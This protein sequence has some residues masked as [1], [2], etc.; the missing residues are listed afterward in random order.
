M[1]SQ[2]SYAAEGIVLKRKSAG[3]ADRIL[4]IFT[5]QY[6]KIRV[7]AKGIRKVGSRRSSYLE[8]F[9]H[10]RFMLVKS[11]SMDILTEVES[12]GAAPETHVNLSSI[13]G[14]Y[15]VCELVDALLPEKM[16]HDEVY[17]LLLRAL[18]AV[19]TSKQPIVLAEF[20]RLLLTILGYYPKG[21]A[22]TVSIDT[23]IENLIEKKLKTPKFLLQIV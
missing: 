5:K 23:I 6:G 13:G 4:T 11:G 2:R 12:V 21:E 20:P 9:R 15:Y 22:P 19:H 7:I 1:R 18:A 16:E 14:A 3:E 10:I 8:V 17:A